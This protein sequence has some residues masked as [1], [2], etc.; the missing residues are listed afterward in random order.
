VVVAG[1]ANRLELID[2]AEPLRTPDE[3]RRLVEARPRW[4]LVDGRAVERDTG[5]DA[6]HDAK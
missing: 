2:L 6:G 1:D 5:R 4:Q 3:L